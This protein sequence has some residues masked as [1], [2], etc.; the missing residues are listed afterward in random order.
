MSQRPTL[1]IKFPTAVAAVVAALM[2]VPQ[3]HAAL[4]IS[5]VLYNESGSDRD[6]EFYEI[7]NNGGA[8]IDLTNYKIGDE[9]TQGSSSVTE[10]M[11]EF[12]AGAMIGPGEVQVVGV[13]ANVFESVY[14]FLPNYEVNVSAGDNAGVPN[15]AVYA[16]WD[17]DGD[18]INGS[19]SN[20]QLL[21]LDGDDN[22]V[23]A[24]N[25]GNTVF[26]DPGLDSGAEADGQ[27]YERINPFVDT[28]TAADWA[29]GSPSSPGQVIPEPATL[30]L[31]AGLAGCLIAGR[32]RLTPT[33]VQ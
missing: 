2:A 29:L 14:G 19:N 10:G 23:D 13:N 6:G 8:A 31:A 3:L 12:P 11:F 33:A 32:R 15:L 24:V 28:D 21:I 26:L 1:L 25:W 22:L 27:S 7:F 30:L 4:V 18:R 5:E 9:E 17:P 20:D 16:A